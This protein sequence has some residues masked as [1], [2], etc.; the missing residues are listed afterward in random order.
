M[1]NE[2]INGHKSLIFGLRELN[3][4]EIINLCLINRSI[5]QNPPI[6]NKIF[7][8]TSNYQIQVYLSACY[9]FDENKNKWIS[10]GLK[11]III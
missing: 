11:V 7:N 2:E 10:N 6:I 8:F 4:S 1:N 5:I 9:Y 3:S